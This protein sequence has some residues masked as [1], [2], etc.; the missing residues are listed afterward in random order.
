MKRDARDPIAKYRERRKATQAGRPF[1]EPLVAERRVTR[2]PHQEIHAARM[3][4]HPLVLLAFLPLVASVVALVTAAVVGWPTMTFVAPWVGLFAAF[5]A[6]KVWR[7]DPRPV[8]TPG[9]LGIE[10]DFVVW[11]GVPVA[12]KGALRRAGSYARADVGTVLEL[13]TGGRLMRRFIV[14]DPDEASALVRKLGFVAAR[15]T[16]HYTAMSRVLGWPSWARVLLFLSIYGAA[17]AAV[18]AVA[19]ADVYL[20]DTA[21]EVATVAATLLTL[22]LYFSSSAIV[23]RPD[24]LSIRWLGTRRVL[25][26]RDIRAIEAREDVE[27][28]RTN[29]GTF[30]STYHVADITLAGGGR[31]TIRFGGR[32]ADDARRDA[33]VAQVRAA[34]GRTLDAREKGRS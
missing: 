20:L 21:I 15:K 8:R 18:I 17:V 2:S 1:L 12:R 6:G 4:R 32:E 3:R 29:V 34:L 5:F 33:F 30:F 19:R 7:D 28:S 27:T 9:W 26:L 16:G 11:N 14:T 10:G 13:D 24:A 22:V 25:P 23:L 31:R